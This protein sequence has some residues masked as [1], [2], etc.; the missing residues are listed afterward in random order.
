MAKL[1]VLL[2]KHGNVI[3]TF[4]ATVPAGSRGAPSVGMRAKADQRLV[5]VT[6]DDA[7]ADLAPDELHKHIKTHHLK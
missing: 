4:R 2:D 7:H 3:G 5:E 6:L 1:Q